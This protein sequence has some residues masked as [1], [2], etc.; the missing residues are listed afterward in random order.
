MY[1]DSVRNGRKLCTF[2]V[3]SGFNE[4]P[5]DGSI[6]VNESIN[7]DTV[8]ELA[9][10]M[11]DTMQEQSHNDKY[12]FVFY[13]NKYGLIQ[14]SMQLSRDNWSE[15]DI[16]YFLYDVALALVAVARNYR[17]HIYKNPIT[18]KNEM[19]K[20]TE[21]ENYI[22]ADCENPN[23]HLVLSR[24]ENPKVAEPKQSYTSVSGASDDFMNIP[25]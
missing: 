5:P 22:L 19:R 7:E 8:N 23:E 11:I 3:S 4:L 14:L 6:R 12:D 1:W 13:F 16:D 2:N 17:V 21:L 25:E 15:E 24:S 9:A 20:L 10:L 18:R